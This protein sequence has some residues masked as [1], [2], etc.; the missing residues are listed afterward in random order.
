MTIACGLQCKAAAQ[1][2]A[3]TDRHELLKR[4]LY[5]EFALTAYHSGETKRPM[6]IANRR[7]ESHTLYSV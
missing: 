7:F 4:S 3:S 5:T 6:H 2:S 1:K